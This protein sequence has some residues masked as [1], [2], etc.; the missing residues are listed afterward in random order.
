MY[1]IRQG[2]PGEADFT[3]Y[4]GA[5]EF[6][7]YKGAEAII[8][9]PAETGKTLGALYKLHICACKYPGASLVICRKTL[10]SAYSTVLVTFQRKVLHD[11]A[12]VQAYGG[13][14]PQWFDYANG[15]RI[16][17]AGM[18]KSSKVLSAEH[19]VVYVNQ[20]EEL[21]LEDWE[22][23]TTRTTGRAGNMPYSQTIG[24]ANPA[25][26]M[27]WIYGRPS[28][29]LFYS[30]HEE[31]PALFDQKTGEL[32][33]Q[34]RRTM[35]VLQ[36]LTG[37]RRTR[38]LDGKPAQAEG[39]IYEDWDESA[40][41]AYAEDLPPLNRYVAGVD[42]GYT[43]PGVIGVWGLDWDGRMYLV[44]QVYR[45][46]QNIG[47]WTARAKELDEEFGVE[48]FA[49][50]PDEPAYIEQFKGAGLN[51]VAAFNR[52]R[53]GIDAVQTRLAQK[54]LFVVR[55][56]ARYADEALKALH[57]PHS[58]EQEFAGYVWANSR[59]KEQPVKE[60]DHGMDM[61]R[62]AVAYVDGV[63]QERK[64]KAR[65]IWHG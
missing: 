40:H 20:A 39:M 46:K 12:P 23:L 59:T 26:P 18:D 48:A 44:A 24:D 3:F 37:T 27:H 15:S 25:W 17:M 11:G 51:A 60:N 30:R 21:A 61:A 14:K 22:T 16:W 4:G 43:N 35:T 2:E 28:L 53:P 31:N 32:T 64:K 42:W 55:D 54:R 52:V 65:V 6:A 19:D 13:E 58:T 5:R 41:L 33:E 45:T 29:R 47:W 7:R 38:L 56:N 8:H 34:G 10:A 1:E 63:G 50:G 9:G 49:C 62:Y 57:K 36:A